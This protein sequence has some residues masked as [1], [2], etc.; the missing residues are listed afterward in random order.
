MRLHMK[1]KY[2]VPSC[3][4]NFGVRLG[5]IQAGERLS[6]LFWV[7]MWD[8]MAGE[9]RQSGNLGGIRSRNATVISDYF[10][11]FDNM[12]EGVKGYFELL[13]LPRY[14]NLKG[15]TEPRRYLETIC[16]WVCDQF[17]LCAENM[18]LIEQ[19]Q[20]MKYDENASGRSA[21]DVLNVMRSW[22]GYSEANGEVPADY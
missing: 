10:R 18:E 5:R 2:A 20:L 21:Q 15:I 4:G 16:R 22:I 14:Q 13:Q 11:V 12:E 17:C 19:Y 7:E 6:Q 9:V 8:E 1:S 3:T